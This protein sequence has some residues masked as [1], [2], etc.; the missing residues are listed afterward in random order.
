MRNWPM[1]QLQEMCGLKLSELGRFAQGYGD[2]KGTEAIFFMTHGEIKAIP[3][4]RTVTYARI[5]VEYR[6]QKEDPDCVHITVGGNQINYSGELTTQSADLTMAKVLWN[7]T[8][9]TDG[10][11]CLCRCG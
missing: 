3:K 7:S 9:S 11:I 2:T 1:I 8:I 5:L 6:P 10:A 4:D